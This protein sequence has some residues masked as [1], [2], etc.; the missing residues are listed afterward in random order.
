MAIAFNVAGSVSVASNGTTLAVPVNIS[1]STNGILVA[2]FNGNSTSGTIKANPTFKGTAMT[3]ICA[4]TIN[5]SSTCVSFIYYLINPGTGLGT[6]AGT[7]SANESRR[8]GIGLAYTGVDQITSIVGSFI[9]SNTGTVGT[10]VDTSLAANNI[11]VGF[12]S[13]SRIPGTTNIG[14]ERG[15]VAASTDIESMAA[16]LNTGSI[17]FRYQSSAFQAWVGVGV[18]LRAADAGATIIGPGWKSLLGVGQI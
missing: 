15:T 3:F 6:I 11:L 5:A 7:F 16:D 4:G 17:I 14:T 8:T 18:E 13:L 12:A 1:D 10:I 2:S 9:S